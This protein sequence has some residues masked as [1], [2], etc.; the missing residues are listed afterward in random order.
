[1]ITCIV[2][3]QFNLTLIRYE[4]CLKIERC[5]AELRELP[6]RCLDVLRTALER[7]WLYLGPRIVIARNE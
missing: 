6:A 1:M 2:V 5:E 3:T 7:L 4:M